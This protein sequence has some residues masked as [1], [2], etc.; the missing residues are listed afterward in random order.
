MPS[1][2]MPSSTIDVVTLFK[3]AVYET[4]GRTLDNLTLDTRIAQLAMDSVVVMETIGLLEEQ[5]AVRFTEDDL[6][7]L[8]TLRDLDALIAS[9]RR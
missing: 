5:L 2:P 3:E 8:T 7:K 9:R 1:A 4:D 6:A